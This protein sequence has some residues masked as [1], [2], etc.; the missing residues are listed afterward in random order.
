M[1]V[2]H[3]SHSLLLL[4]CCC[5]CCCYDLACVLQIAAYMNKMRQS[6]LER[7]A[8]KQDDEIVGIVGLYLGATMVIL[9][10]AVLANLPP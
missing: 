3:D 10:L 7:A 5:C 9:A 1:T 6:R 8:Y 4:L 2:V